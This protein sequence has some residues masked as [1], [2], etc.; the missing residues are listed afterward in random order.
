M[1]TCLISFVTDSVQYTNIVKESLGYETYMKK[2]E[3]KCF[4]LSASG[5]LYYTE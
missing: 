2:K 1:T 5:F 4:S 3:N